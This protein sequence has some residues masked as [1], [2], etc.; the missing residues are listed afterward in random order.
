[1]LKK[2][3]ILLCGCMLMLCACKDVDDPNQ[4]ESKSKDAQ[5]IET[6]NETESKIEK[7]EAI[8][9]A[10]IKMQLSPDLQVDCQISLPEKG[11]NELKQYVVKNKFFNGAA[12]AVQLYPELN[13]DAI[14]HM[15]YSNIGVE[16]AIMYNGNIPLETEEAEGSLVV[17]TSV[18]MTTNR[19]QN[20][21]QL[22][23]ADSSDYAEFSNKQLETIDFETAISKGRTALEDGIGIADIYLNSIYGFSK[24]YLSAVSESINA[25]AE[26]DPENGKNGAI[27]STYGGDEEIYLISYEQYYNGIPILTECDPN[28]NEEVQPVFRK[29]G[30][31]SKGIEFIQCNYNIEEMEAEE[32]EIKSI[33]EILQGLKNKMDIVMHEPL[34]VKSMRLTYALCVKDPNTF[35][36]DM[37]LVWEISC[38][39]SSENVKIYYNAV[40][41]KEL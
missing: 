33:D 5:N 35:S 1:M 34:T 8:N 28:S 40:T 25:A 23:P 29:I 4:N 2:I 27:V 32:V 6:V 21:G 14:V 39:G 38:E 17:G 16:S 18:V 12:V 36:H 30:V 22:L 41:G 9:G 37:R 13:Q 10:E 11:I 26:T 31:T 7:I 3:S 24:E 20:L 19:W 15:D